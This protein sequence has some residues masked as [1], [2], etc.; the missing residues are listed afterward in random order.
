MGVI[1]PPDRVKLFAGLLAPDEESFHN[2]EA[3]I[4]ERW[5]KIDHRG[6]IL[7]FTYTDYYAP[8]MGKTLMRRWVSFETLIEPS[9]LAGIKRYSNEVEDSFACS[10][11]R[12]VNI[13]PGY[14][15]L[16]KI[17]LAST[18]D[19]SHRIYLSDGIYAEITLLY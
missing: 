1:K 7:P 12:V 2:A 4:T 17:V 19:F 14:L 13:D 6:P 10:G 18:K 15:A 9:Q 16:S 11:K 8:E 3:T 5:G